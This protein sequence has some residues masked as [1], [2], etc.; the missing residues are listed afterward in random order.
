MMQEVALSPVM[1]PRELLAQVASY[2]PTPYD[3]ARGDQAPGARDASR[4]A[5]TSNLSGGQKR[6]VQFAHGDLS[7]APSCC[8]STN[9]RVGLD[10]QAREA[11]WQV[12]RELMHEGCSIVL[13]THY[14]EEAEAL[15]NRVAV[16]AHGR[17]VA[18][19]SVDEIRAHVS[20]KQHEL[21]AARSPRDAV[22]A[23]PEVMRARAMER[24]RHA[25]HHAQRRSGAA[26]ACSARTPRVRDIEVKRAGLA[27]AFTELTNDDANQEARHER[28]RQHADEHS[29]LWR[30]LPRRHPLRV[31]QVAAHAGLRACRR[32][33]SR[34]MFYLLFG[35]LHGQRAG[36][37]R[38]GA[39]FV[40]RTIGV[41]GAM[42]PGPV[43]LR[44]VARLRARARA[45]RAQAGAAA[46][47]PAPT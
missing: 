15:A 36:Q 46:C 9:P 25:D 42:A 16:M 17:L 44:R 40:R 5:L 27:E 37:R 45:A 35:V 8:S 41:F 11:L 12:V 34:S 32:C 33:S 4:S 23:W 30:R 20:R 18:G 21:R 39:V 31:H 26:R 47:R 6:Q 1:R 29:R 2:Y 43:R 14:L 38:D 28:R 24:D 22:R 7:A 3:V 10:V 13:T 19:G